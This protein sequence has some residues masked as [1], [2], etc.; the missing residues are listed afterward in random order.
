N[1]RNNKR[2]F[3]CRFRAAVFVPAPRKYH[4][5][6]R[7]SR[8]GRRTFRTRGLQCGAM[9]YSSRRASSDAFVAHRTLELPKEAISGNAGRIREI[10][11]R[12]VMPRLALMPGSLASILLPALGCLALGCVTSGPPA[13]GQAGGPTP[14]PPG[15][16]VYFIGLNDGDTVPTK[17]TIHFG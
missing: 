9:A 3:M 8:Q 16:A 4:A 10:G 2:K 13:F 17:S 1:I 6:F 15:A 5:S 7:Q 11:E 14:S 12:A